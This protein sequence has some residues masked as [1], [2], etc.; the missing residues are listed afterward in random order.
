MKLDDGFASNSFVKWCDTKAQA[1]DEVYRL[2]GW[3]TKNIQ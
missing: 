2:N 3:K 1:K